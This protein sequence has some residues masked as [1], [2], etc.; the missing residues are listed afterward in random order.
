MKLTVDL[1]ALWAAVHE[2]GEHQSD[3][4]LDMPR[5]ST[6]LAFDSELSSIIGMPIKREDI[7]LDKGVLSVH[8]RQVLLFIP[9]QGP[10]ISEVLAGVKEGNK[11]HIADCRTLESKRSDNS[12]DRYKATYNVSGRFQVFGVIHGARQKIE[13]EAKLTVCKNCLHYLNYEGYR[14]ATTAKKDNI[15]R[16]FDIAAF[17]SGYS[18]LFRN[19]P[20][21]AALV[22]MSGYTD[23]WKAVSAR[24]RKSVGFC[25]EFCRVDLNT[26][27]HL[28]HSHHI[29]RNKEDNSDANLQALCLD[30]HRKQPQH[31]YMRVKHDE[32]VKLTELR[33]VQGLLATSDWDEVIKLADKALDGLLKHYQEKGIT[34]PEVGYEVCKPDQSVAAELEIAWPDKRRGIALSDADLQAASELGWHVTGVGEELK[35][36]NK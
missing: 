25:C 31:E 7:E 4:G 11:F 27:R 6:E 33:R 8:G 21:R 32:M 30:C 1:T 36:M 23:D 13:G 5:E 35:R 9:D 10:K 3:F 2:M 24:Y 20:D 17:L 34:V 12:F 15:Y 18:T 29:N 26:H 16:G 14:S 22:D 28:L 19:M